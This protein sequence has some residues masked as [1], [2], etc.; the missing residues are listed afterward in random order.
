MDFR[1][2]PSGDLTLTNLPGPGC[3]TGSDR[4]LETIALTIRGG[5][6]AA[7]GPDGRL[8]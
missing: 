1:A 2:L 7:P 3:L 8:P 5:R 4:A 6:I